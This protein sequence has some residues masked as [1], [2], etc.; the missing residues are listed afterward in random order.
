MEES[1]KDCS[2]GRIPL[3]MRFSVII[4]LY[5]KAPYIQK[6][7][8]SV[9]AQSFK[10]FELVVVDDG[11]RDDSYRI[12]KEILE[13]TP[14]EYQLI[15]QE[16]A[17]VSTARNNGVAASHGDYLCFLDADDWWAPTFLEKM[18]YLIR[19]YPDAG[20]YGTNY[21]YVKNGR[22]RVC[23]TTAETGYINYCQV[24]AE[25]LQMPLWTGAVCVPRIIFEEMGG[26]RPHLKLGEDFDLWIKIALKY[27]VAFLNEPHSYYSQDSDATW[28]L[29][30]KLHNPKTHM[31]WNLEYL[32]EEEK[33]NPDYKRLI[34]NLRTYSLLPYYLSKQYRD[35][36]KQELAKV[37]WDS[38]PREVRSKY[39]KPIPVLKLE[40]AFMRCGSA[41]KQ[42][43][44]K[45][46]K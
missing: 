13:R 12:A 14:V 42:W 20:I 22:Q 27:K 3:S 40:R 21:Y 2:R 28:R 37:D 4:P 17:G 34:D 43:V 9:F 10:D 15:H 44:I 41:V 29:V 33:T 45:H 5:N 46:K 6:A 25:K 24:Y 11:S 38:Q 30:G 8:E 39:N 23:V 26:F 35:E 18:D 32:E 16:N 31:L 1:E 7:L 36:A 19:D